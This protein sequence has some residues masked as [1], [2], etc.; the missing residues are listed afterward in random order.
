MVAIV[1]GRLDWGLQR[2]PE[3]GREYGI[4]WLLRTTGVDDGPSTV[5]LCPELPQVGNYWAFGNETDPWAFCRPDWTIDC[6]GKGEPG[7]YWTVSQTFSTRPLRRCQEFQFDNPLMEPYEIGGTFINFQK[8]F[9]RDRFGW[10]M[11]MSS[12]E[13]VRGNLMEFDRGKPT[14]TISFNDAILG[15]ETFTDFQDT[16]NDADLW[17]FKPRCV[18]L[19]NTT[20]KRNIYGACNYY[21]TKTHEFQ[22]DTKTHDREITDMGTRCLI[23]YSPGS[24]NKALKKLDPTAPDPSFGNLPWYYNPANF[25]NY[26]DI[27]GD[28]AE[29]FLDGVGRPVINGEDAH[30]FTVQHYEE[31]NFLELGIPAVIEQ[32]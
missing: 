28:P 30:T 27:N 9:S 11:R 32:S 22:I 1:V 6:L 16:V 15:M 24:P 31:R 26:I 13:R 18:K 2:T 29:C 12:S 8:E 10:V 7:I 25:E 21:Y 19:S 17:G 5:M 4:T 14:I 23:G 3:N 20:W